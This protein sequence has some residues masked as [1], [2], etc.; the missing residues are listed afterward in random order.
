MIKPLKEERRTF[1]A[2]FGWT[3]PVFLAVFWVMYFFIFNQIYAVKP[4]EKLTFFYAAYGLKETSFHEDMRKELEATPCYEVNYYDYSLNDSTIYTK[5]S[6]VK[7]SCDFFIFS[8]HDLNEI[9]DTIGNNFKQVDDNQELFSQVELSAHYTF[10]LHSG[11]KYG[12]KLFDKDD[13]VYNEATKFKN[14]I[15]FTFGDKKDSFYLVINKNSVNFS[16]EHILGYLGMRYLFN[17][18]GA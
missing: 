15:N 17:N 12:I 2:Y 7:D 3:I 1:F 4:F 10:Y 8:E 13:E 9:G 16:S 5:Y 11:I 6:A 14:Y 18:V